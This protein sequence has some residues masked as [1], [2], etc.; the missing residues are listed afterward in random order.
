M[1]QKTRQREV[2]MASAASYKRASAL[3][4]AARNSSLF[5]H[6]DG[7]DDPSTVDAI[8]EDRSD[9]ARDAQCVVDIAG[10]EMGQALHLVGRLTHQGGVAGTRAETRLV[11]TSPRLAASKSLNE[12]RL[13]ALERAFRA[14]RAGQLT[15]GDR[16]VLFMTAAWHFHSVRQVSSP[17][18]V[19]RAA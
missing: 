9:R 11:E 3:D 1:V 7:L 12:E 2:P 15:V 16:M 13:L 6:F 18:D 10:T 4:R 8:E 14:P 17:E 19:A 5:E